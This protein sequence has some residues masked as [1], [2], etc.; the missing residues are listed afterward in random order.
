MPQSASWRSSV[1]VAP[2][3]AKRPRRRHIF[4]LRYI[5]LACIAAWGAFDYFHVE[6]P[7][8]DAL[9][10]KQSQLEAQLND[11]KQ[12]RTDLKQQIQELH[13][14]DYIARYATHEFHLVSPG[15]VPFSVQH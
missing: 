14:K 10:Q 15:E 5:G 6:K 4:K 12:Q 1:S 2:R 11:L 13:D 3:A 9:L 7:R 8:L